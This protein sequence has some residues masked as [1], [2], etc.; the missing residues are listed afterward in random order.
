M[1][2][3]LSRFIK[4]KSKKL[5]FKQLVYYIKSY[6]LI[7]GIRTFNQILTPKTTI[8][9]FSLKVPFTLSNIPLKVSGIAVIA[10]IYYVDLTN[11]ILDYL[12]NIPYDYDLFISTDTPQK[13]NEIDNILN[14]R[15]IHAATVKVFENRGRDIAPMIVGF[16]EL[17][18]KYTYVL[19]IHSKKSIHADLANWRKYAFDNL[20]G[21]PDIVCSIMELFTK[22][23]IGVVFPAHYE[24]IKPYLS[25]GC[26]YE[27]V[28]N[29]VK[30]AN[31][32][33]NINSVLEFP[34]GS[35]FWAKT[36]ALKKMVDLN[37]NFSDF[38]EE[39]GQ[40]N[41]TLAHAIE[42]SIL[43]FAEANGYT[44]IRV[45]T[46]NNIDSKTVLEIKDYNFQECFNKIYIPLGV[47][48]I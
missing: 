47:L 28:K 45:S 1:F 31:I 48:N 20:L 38:P 41:G 37:L 15:H 43:Y 6:G 10:H 23:D 35:M 22:N 33:I 14:L 36:D 42:R 29:L 4:S 21:S 7:R 34:S 17:F 9:D 44:W 5:F 27:I 12:N 46:D 39:K 16:A 40:I 13:K 11:E 30:K 24:F 2:K 3:H 18:N 26:N 8:N 19:H 25:W 32:Q